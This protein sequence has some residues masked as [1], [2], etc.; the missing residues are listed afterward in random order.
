MLLSKRNRFQIQKDALSAMLPSRDRRCM[1]ESLYKTE[2][3]YNEMSARSK[4]FAINFIQ[5]YICEI[6]R[7]VHMS[8]SETPLRTSENSFEEITE[9]PLSGIV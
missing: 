9:I 1:I 4:L 3:S 5:S 6:G 8:R 7:G 2:F